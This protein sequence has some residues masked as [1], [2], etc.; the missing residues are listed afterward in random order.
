LSPSKIL[1]PGAA[2]TTSPQVAKAKSK[3]KNLAS[4]R[5]NVRERGGDQKSVVAYLEE[6][7]D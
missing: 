7:L 6:W 1:R 4:L 3:E 2:S 5:K